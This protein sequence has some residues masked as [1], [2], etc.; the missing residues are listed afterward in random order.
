M[1]NEFDKKKVEA[2]VGAFI[3]KRRPPPHI[4]KELDLG[5][6]LTGHSVEIFE[7]RP[8][9][10]GNG[11]THEVP[12]AKATFVMSR[13]V[14][15]LYWQRQNLKWYGYEPLPEVRAI[16]AIVAEI[17]ADPHACFWG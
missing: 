16:E 4:R 9:W 7:V 3:E 14:W 1:L 8:V 12:V 15:K 13:K 6:R 5:F 17:D 11:E 2:V 10:N